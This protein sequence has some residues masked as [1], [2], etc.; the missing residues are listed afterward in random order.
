MGRLSFATLL[1]AQLLATTAFMFVVPFMPLYVQQ[2]GVQDAENAAAWAG[3]INGASGASMALVAPLWGRLSDRLGRKLMLLRATLA[4]AIVVGSMG[5]VSAPWQLLGLRLLQGTL[6]GTVPA[7]TALVAF[8]APPERAGWRLGALQTVIFIAAGIGPALGGVSADLAGIRTSFLVTSALLAVSGALVLLGVA[9]A[10]PRRDEVGDQEHEESIGSHH[11]PLPYRL[12]LPGLLTLFAVHMTIT[13]ASVALPGFVY[14][15]ASDAG[16][17]ASQAGWILGTGALVASLGSLLGGKLV[18]R[19]GPQGMIAMS[20]ALAGLAA[21]PQA[22]AA[23]VTELWVLRLIT[24]LFL[25]C[26]IPVANLVIKE[27][28]PPERQGAAFGLASSATSIGFALGPI[29]GGLLASG[30]GFWAAFLVP[31]AALLALAAT[32][33]FVWV[34]RPRSGKGAGAWRNVIAY[35][36]R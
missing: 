29:G 9:E 10:K 35:F 11:N 12:L 18:S 21:M 14:T 2:L 4:A 30:L 5:F 31:G 23:N 1:V 16:R 17:I 6:T 22:L 19:F 13:S 34:P 32:F 28:A 36:T 26:A 33:V 7:A 24:S 25:G 15:L 8:T 3:F 20:L 27:V